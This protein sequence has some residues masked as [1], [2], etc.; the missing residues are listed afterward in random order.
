[1]ITDRIER[2][3]VI[4]AQPERVWDVITQAEHLGTWF[5]DAG[6]EIDLRPGGRL[7]LHWKEHGTAYGRVETVD[8]HTTFSFRWVMTEGD[9]PTDGN[10]TVVVFT[11]TPQDG[12]THLHVVETGFAGLEVTPEQQEKRLGENIEGWQL[13]LDELRGYA[14]SM[15]A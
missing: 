7:T 15:S 9:E 8:A 1:M 13:K 10:S 4:S 3:I 6:A 14:E 11:L 12:G 5:G 2:E